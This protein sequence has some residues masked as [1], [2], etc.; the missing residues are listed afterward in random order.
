[1]TYSFLQ[2]PGDKE[3]VPWQQDLDDSVKP[4]QQARPTVIRWSE[5]GKEVFI[6]GSFNNWSAKIPLIKR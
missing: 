3:F 4:T 6:S 1:M 2:L 5:G